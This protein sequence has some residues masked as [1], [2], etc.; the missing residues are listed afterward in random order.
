MTEKISKKMG[1]LPGALI[2]V[3]KKR[4]FLTKIDLINYSK[5]NLIAKKEISLEYLKKSYNQETVNWIDIRGLHNINTIKEIGTLF[6]ID[7][8]HLEDILNTKHRPKIQE[9][10]HYILLCLK[11]ISY[12]KNHKKPKIRQLTV[13][14]FK[15][16]VLTF[17]EEEECHLHI[18]KKR[19]LDGKGNMQAHGN[20]FLMYSITDLIID[21]YFGVIDKFHDDLEELENSIF[22]HFDEKILLTIQENKKIIIQLRRTIF[23]IR[24]EI[25]TLLKHSSK[26]ITPKT[27]EYFHDIYEHIY[28][29]MESIE[30]IR[31][32]NSGLKDL[33]LSKINLRMNQIMQTLTIF[34]SIFIPLT[35]ISGLY[36]MN[37][38]NM[39]ELSWKYG[40]HVTI[41]I[42]I[43]V[44]ISLLI[45]FKI[46]KWF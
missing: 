15:N 35:F 22:K 39:P 27:L 14:L 46:K 8:L 33:Y 44:S 10:E 19:I 42:M 20:D 3:G 11:T 21:E 38:E 1:M 13:V 17:Q 45:Y 7:A 18:I 4:N 5:K 31:E 26:L 12:Q 34:A 43:L 28:F 16:L 37:F 32:I 6:K 36:G 40:Y 30:N 23:P 2:Y 9:T 29:H 24:E 25:F 41:S